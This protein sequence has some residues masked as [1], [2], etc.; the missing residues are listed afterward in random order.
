LTTLHRFITPEHV[1]T[2]VRRTRKG[3]AVGVDGQT[4]EDFAENLADNI[5]D[6]ISKAKSG[7]YRA[8]P[9]RRVHIP[10][11]D[12]T[13]RPLGIPTYTDKVLQRAVLMLL[14]PIYEGM[15]HDSSYGFRPGRS[16]H[17]CVKNIR[18]GIQQFNGCYVLDVDVSK[19][20]D[21]IPHNILRYFVKLRVQDGV[22][23]RLI[24]KWLNAGILEEGREVSS[25]MGAPQGGV[26]SPLLSNIYLHYVLDEWVRNVVSRHVRGQIKLFRFADDFVI[27]LKYEKDAHRVMKALHGR[28]NKYGLQVH[29][30]K[31]KIVNMSRSEGDRKP[32]T[33]NFLGFTFFWG[34][35]RGKK[36]RIV[37]VQT[38]S[39]RLT[40]ILRRLNEVCRKIR[41]DEPSEQWRKLKAIL[42]GF[43]SYHNVSLNRRAVWRIAYH[44]TKAWHKWLNRR[45][46]K[47]K[48]TWET[49]TEVWQKRFPLPM[50]LAGKAKAMW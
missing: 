32:E 18:E 9:V 1:Q 27:L 28:L 16:A 38:A 35:T 11:S 12:G 39:D 10:K 22:V 4:S 13:K 44:A 45:D 50:P 40:R 41:H 37:R 21:T 48:V 43:Y 23:N 30:D 31:S 34:H 6:L 49:F 20:F 17:E 26:L 5:G 25:T 24:S 15:F 29:P 42:N 46:Q 8:P 19:Y 7:S 2:A 47:G 14:E 36:W 33:F 3:G